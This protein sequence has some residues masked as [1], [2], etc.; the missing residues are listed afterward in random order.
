[1]P[2]NL[3]QVDRRVGGDVTL[4]PLLA[5]RPHVSTIRVEDDGVGSGGCGPVSVAVSQPPRRRW[6][7]ADVGPGDGDEV[8]ELM[9]GLEPGPAGCR[10]L[11]RRHTT[12][13][14]CRQQLRAATVSAKLKVYFF[15]FQAQFIS[16]SLAEKAG[17]RT[18]IQ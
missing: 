14:T 13:S 7:L 6:S 12:V 10:S 11:P 1:M 3:A 18:W 8:G 5:R 2:K 15:A 9:S 16:S 4:S 17:V